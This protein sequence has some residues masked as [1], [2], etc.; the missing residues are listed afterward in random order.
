MLEQVRENASDHLRFRRKKVKEEDKRRIEELI[1]GMECPK[2]F[3]CIDSNSE[4][5][6]KAKDFGLEN[7]LECLD[8][9]PHACKFTLR[10]GDRYFCYCPLRVYLNKKLK[11]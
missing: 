8:H 2:G 5:L 7:Y 3:R 1:A 6:C 11:K 9:N 4:D 10:F